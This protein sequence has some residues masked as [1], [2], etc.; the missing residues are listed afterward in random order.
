MP[1]QKEQVFP[2]I[3]TSSID[4]SMI[5]VHLWHD[6]IIV[7]ISNYVSKWILL[8]EATRDILL[9]EEGDY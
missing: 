7:L 8:S 2:N 5:H 3:E 1:L 4:E 9:K 6:H